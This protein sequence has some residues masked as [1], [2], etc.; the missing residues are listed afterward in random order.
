[1]THCNADKPGAQITWGSPMIIFKSTGVTYDFKKL[2]IRNII[3][4]T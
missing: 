3:P 2:S 1:M 4:P